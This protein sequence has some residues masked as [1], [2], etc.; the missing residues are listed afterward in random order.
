MPTTS[1]ASTS[2]LPCLYN[3]ESDAYNSH[4]ILSS[5]ELTCTKLTANIADIGI[6]ASEAILRNE[7]ILDNVSSY[8]ESNRPKKITDDVEI[9]TSINLL[10][11][12][13]NALHDDLCLLR[14][15]VYGSYI[16]GIAVG[17]EVNKTVTLEGRN[18]YI[19]ALGAYAQTIEKFKARILIMPSIFAGLC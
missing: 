2:P 12:S 9:N 1:P 5:N 8:L 7:D 18:K 16:A 13:F 11:E 6:L 14:E 17:C 3:K 4:N 19:N 15:E 10:K